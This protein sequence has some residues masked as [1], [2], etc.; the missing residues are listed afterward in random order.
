LAPSAPQLAEP[1]AAI[2]YAPVA[3]ASAAYRREQIALAANGFGFLIP[4]AEKIRTLGTVFNSSLFPRRAPAGHVELTSFIGGATDLEAIHFSD[5]QLSRIAHNDNA[6]LLR[7]SGEPCATHVT[8]WPRAIPQYNLGHG[9]LIAGVRAQLDATPALFL[10]GNYLEGP[11]L[12]KCVEN[13]GH[14]ADSVATFLG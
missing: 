5:A 7:I 4:R 9:R 2:P 6:R 3:V 1:L 10:C 8:R 14:A 12:S 11:A 13:G